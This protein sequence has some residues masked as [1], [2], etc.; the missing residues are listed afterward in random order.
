MVFNAITN[1]ASVQI[2]I[3]T[4]QKTSRNQNSGETMSEDGWREGDAARIATHSA[5]YFYF[6][7]NNDDARRL[8]KA[9]LYSRY[10]G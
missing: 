3:D 7:E 2:S 10:A 5:P 1:T 9:R 8:H 6:R 4:Q